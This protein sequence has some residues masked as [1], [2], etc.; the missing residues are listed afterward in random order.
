MHSPDEEWGNREFSQN[1]KIRVIPEDGNDCT[2]TFDPDWENAGE[3]PL[4]Q[5]S[6]SAKR[7]DLDLD[8]ALAI[9]SARVTT[10]T[11]IVFALE[12]FTFQRDVIWLVVALFAGLTRRTSRHRRA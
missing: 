3:K 4:N 7:T 2:A 10:T 6:L 9:T 11:R 5:A 8:V 1:R 12:Q